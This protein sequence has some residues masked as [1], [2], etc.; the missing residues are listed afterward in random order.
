MGKPWGQPL[1]SIRLPAEDKRRLEYLARQ[2]NTTV[3]EIVRSLISERI[4]DVGNAPSSDEL[5]GQ[6]HI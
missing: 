5:P 1:L 2:E 3:T 4:K 6:M